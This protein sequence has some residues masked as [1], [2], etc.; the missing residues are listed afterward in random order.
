MRRCDLSTAGDWAEGNSHHIGFSPETLESI[1]QG[2][3]RARHRSHHHPQH[4]LD[5]STTI[6][7]DA[8]APTGPASIRKFC[9]QATGAHTAPASA[10]WISTGLPTAKS[11]VRLVVDPYHRGNIPSIKADSFKIPVRI[12]DPIDPRGKL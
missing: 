2:S 11:L 8:N 7:C 9:S 5:R 3:H 12:D 4:A 1:C 10:E 6:R